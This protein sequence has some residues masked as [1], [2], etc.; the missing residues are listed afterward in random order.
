VGL[1]LMAWFGP[2]LP[3]W[4]QIGYGFV[5]AGAIGNGIDR[6]ATG[7][8]VDFLDFRL[9]NFPV[10]NVADI[11]INIGIV[12]LLIAAWRSPGPH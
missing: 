1:M 4:Q 3:F 9:I 8:V 5:L 7:E 2:R 11:C 6:F 10:F 12:C